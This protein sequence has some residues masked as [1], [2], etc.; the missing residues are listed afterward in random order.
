MNKTTVVAY[1]VVTSENEPAESDRSD[2]CIF[3]DTYTAQLWMCEL[4]NVRDCGLNL[5]M[6]KVAI[7]VIEEYVNPRE[8]Q[9]K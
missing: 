7:Q 8:L 6:R 5:H 2:L 4:E 9:V 1:Q 3:P